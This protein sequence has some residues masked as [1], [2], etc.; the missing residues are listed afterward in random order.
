MKHNQERPQ[1]A[2]GTAATAHVP[3]RE[4]IMQQD[5]T[6]LR[7]LLRSHPVNQHVT[8][9]VDPAGCSMGQSRLYLNQVLASPARSLSALSTPRA[10]FCRV[11]TP[12]SQGP[13]RK[14]CDWR[15]VEPGWKILPVMLSSAP[16]LHLC[17]GV[18][19]PFLAHTFFIV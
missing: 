2:G 13:R 15:R 16:R 4:A 12:P 8:V 10:V 6:A 7:A 14:Q 11:A 18:T 17:A 3:L 9:P 1:G 19:S 5:C